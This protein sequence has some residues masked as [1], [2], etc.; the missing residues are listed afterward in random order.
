MLP[1]LRSASS[2]PLLGKTV[3]VNPVT[4]VILTAKQQAIL[5]RLKA[6]VPPAFIST[7]PNGL[8][9]DIRLLGM[10]GMAINDINNAQPRQGLTVETFPTVQYDF[11]V[12]ATSFFIL[13]F[14]QMKYSLADISYS[15][16]GYSITLDRTGKIGASLTNFKEIYQMQL[17]GYKTSVMLSQ[18]FVG[19]GT[20]RNGNSVFGRMMSSLGLGSGS[21]F[22]WNMP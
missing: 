21:A 3:P 11:L 9:Q 10:V 1:L 15:E 18:P 17:Q 14:E 4:I 2:S 16:N 12:L 6:V 13:M 19:L 8:G 20:P 7:V 5:N 22:S